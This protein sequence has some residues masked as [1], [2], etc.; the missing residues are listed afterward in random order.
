[1]KELDSLRILASDVVLLAEKKES[2]DVFMTLDMRMFSARVNSN[3]D[4]VTK[5][6]IDEI[7]SN[8]S[9]YTCLPLWADTKCMKAGN[10]KSLDHRYNK[11][12]GTYGTEQ[13]GSFCE[14]WEKEDPVHGGTSLYGRCRIPKRDPALC[15]AIK[16]MY[17][18]GILCF[19]FEVRYSKAN[20]VMDGK[21]MIIQAAPTNKLTGMA[22]VS[23]PAFE[24]AIA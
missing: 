14:F 1:M 21:A 6:F 4:G 22:V 11:F 24:E 18:Q 7:V 9:Y 8:Q 15:A 12:N 5:E 3:G 19:S 2:N 17:D 16:D 23:V 13:I 10:Y 20:T